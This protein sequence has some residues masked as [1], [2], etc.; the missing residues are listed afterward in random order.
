MPNP[1]SSGVNKAILGQVKLGGKIK[2]ICFNFLRNENYVNNISSRN[3]ALRKFLFKIC[4][5]SFVFSYHSGV[6]TDKIW[7]HQFFK[8]QKRSVLNIFKSQLLGPSKQQLVLITIQLFKMA[9]EK[10]IN[11]QNTSF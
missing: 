5:E 4:L 11:Q 9:K 7:A 2:T 10:T 1:W 6:N 8:E 3:S